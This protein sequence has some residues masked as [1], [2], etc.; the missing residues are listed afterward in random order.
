MTVFP[1]DVDVLIA[2]KFTGNRAWPCGITCFSA[3]SAACSAVR[4]INTVYACWMESGHDAQLT[5]SPLAGCRD[6]RDTLAKQ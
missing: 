6:A 4:K 3:G 1:I 2:V 5:K